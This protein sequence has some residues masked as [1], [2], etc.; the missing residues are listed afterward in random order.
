VNNAGIEIGKPLVEQTVEEFDRLFRY[1]RE[2]RVPRNQ[3]RDAALAASVAATRQHCRRSPGWAGCRCSAP[4]AARRAAVLR[5]TRDRG[6]S[7]FAG[8]HPGQRGVPVVHR[9]EDGGNG[10]SALRRATGAKSPMS[11]R[12]SSAGWAQ[13]RRS[14]RWW[15]SWPR[16]TPIRDRRALHPRRRT[17]REPVLMASREPLLKDRTPSSRRGQGPRRRVRRGARLRGRA[18]RGDRHRR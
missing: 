8:G 12:S 11:W 14:P 7:S 16:T 18:R 1:K 15:R 5:L 9:H 10:W 2:G 6:R 3:A 4:T 13:P 17:D